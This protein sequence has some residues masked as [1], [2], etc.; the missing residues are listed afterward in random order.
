MRK[1]F[2]QALYC[3]GKTLSHKRADSFFKDKD[4]RGSEALFPEVYSYTFF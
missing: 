2:R 3:I 1:A 4:F